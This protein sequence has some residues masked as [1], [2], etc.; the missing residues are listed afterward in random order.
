M[1]EGV[2]ECSPPFAPD[3]P[4]F[5]TRRR[6]TDTGQLSLESGC[7]RPTPRPQGLLQLDGGLSKFELFEAAARSLNVWKVLFAP[8]AHGGERFAPRRLPGDP[9]LKSVCRDVRLA[10][11]T[12]PS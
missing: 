9:Q 5:S 8:V 12:A 2:A 11:S 7:N 3:P 10:S 4:L 6:S 1:A